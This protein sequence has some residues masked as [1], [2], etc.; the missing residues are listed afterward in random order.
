LNS[1][2]STTLVFLVQVM[3]ATILASKIIALAAAAAA[4]AVRNEVES[5][6]VRFAAPRDGATLASSADPVTFRFEVASWAL[7]NLSASD[8]TRL[9]LCFTVQNK[10]E[11]Y[12]AFTTCIDGTSEPLFYNLTGVMP[13]I[14]VAC[15]YLTYADEP[16]HWRGGHQRRLGAT[17][18][19]IWFM[20][21][22]EAWQRSAGL[23]DAFDVPDPPSEADMEAYRRLRVFA[24]A[25]A[26]A[27]SAEVHAQVE[28]ASQMHSPEA[29][30]SS[31]DVQSGE[32]GTCSNFRYVAVTMAN[33]G[34]L[35]L[36]LNLLHS[37]ETHEVPSLIFT[38][39]DVTEGAIA[40]FGER[41]S[42][43]TSLDD[44]HAVQ[45]AVKVP[46][47]A[48]GQS[49][50]SSSGRESP[51]SHHVDAW[52]AGFADITVL[53]PA[54]VWA[55]LRLGVHALWLDTDIVVFANPF[56]ELLRLEPRDL[57]IQSGEKMTSLDVSSDDLDALRNELCMGLY[58]ARPSPAVLA[59]MRHTIHTLALHE[60]D[61]KFGDQAATV[62]VLHE[63]FRSDGVGGTLAS[64]S[65]GVLNALQYPTAGLFFGA[66]ESFEGN[67]V[68]PVLVHNNNLIG[69]A[70]KVARFKAHNL[71]FV[72]GSTLA[73]PDVCAARGSSIDTL[74]ALREQVVVCPLI[75]S[76][77]ERA[78][79][80]L[81]HQACTGSSGDSN[82]LWLN[83]RAINSNSIK[84]RVGAKPERRLISLV[85]LGERPWLEAFV[86]PRLRSYATR[87]H[88]DFL[89]LRALPHCAADGLNGNECSKLSKLRILQA[90]LAAPLASLAEVGS[91]MSWSLDHCHRPVMLYIQRKFF[92]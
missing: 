39:D 43:H 75:S 17:E 10:R 41:K 13:G 46:L 12:Q 47:G 7:G 66:P 60:H 79:A 9:R 37:L 57:W 74:V 90:A 20:V 65:L 15:A 29:R 82:V 59:V 3:W 42:F 25:D 2:T 50:S 70:A 30:C 26:M 83:K 6:P 48:Y 91:E 81:K 34:H 8:E 21:E 69:H 80:C 89:L 56:H 22:P 67:G 85:S 78:N 18:H 51:L 36:A 88:A 16:E 40:A 1:N 63:R 31:S 77:H 76:Q 32:S 5:L 84:N 68:F 38:L 44:N 71:W 54:I 28:V 33:A 27:A 52:S 87:V 73:Q 62:L 45:V 23:T 49:F 64:I 24:V 61:V 35:D 92:K 72:T 55:V 86:L 11:S 58:F 53:K 4:A 14:W 19:S